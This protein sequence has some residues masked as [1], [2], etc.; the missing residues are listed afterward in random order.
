MLT[1]PVAAL[2]VALLFGDA[3][4]SQ[5]VRFAVIDRSGWLGDATRHHIIAA[6]VAVFLDAIERS[7]PDEP[8]LAEVLAARGTVA[9]PAVELIHTLAVESGRLRAPEA[10]HE[11]FAQW[12]ID[13]PNLVRKAAPDV[14]FARFREVHP[15]RP[16][17]GLERLFDEGGVDGYVIIPEDSVGTDEL[18]RYVGRYRGSGLEAW[19]VELAEGLIHRQRRLEEGSTMRGPGP[20]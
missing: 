3:A 4:R 11:R 9:A 16:I 13:H 14:S 19:Y 6:D 2:V 17:E 10:L 20:L 5:P 15:A 7:L 18:P 8:L 12:W 1:I